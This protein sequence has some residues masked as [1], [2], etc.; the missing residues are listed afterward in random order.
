MKKT[1]AFLFLLG[2][3]A[4][5]PAG[6]SLG[7]PAAVKKR[8]DKLDDK[9]RAH[10]A[11]AAAPDRAPQIASAAADSTTTAAG[12]L[13]R[14]SVAA[15]DPDLD[16]LTYV[17]TSTAGTFGGS[18]ASVYWLAPP[19]AGG[20]A[21]SCAV[22]D[23]KLSVSTSVYVRA[24]PGG[25]IKWKFTAAGALN[26]A[27]VIG[28]D[29]T[30]YIT[31]LSG[32]VYAVGAGGA[33]KWANLG[34][35]L[36]A[37]SM[38]YSP[39]LAP[40]GSVYAVD[41][42]ALAVYAFNPDGT[43]KWSS[44]MTLLSSPPVSLDAPPV[45]G[46]DGK[47]YVY[48]AASLAVWALDPATGVAVS[49][50]TDLSGIL[51]AP[52]AGPNGSIYVAANDGTDDLLYAVPAAGLGAATTTVVNGITMPPAVGA[53]GSVYWTDGSAAYAAKPDGTAKWLTPFSY[54]PDTA[55]IG[56]LLGGDGNIYVVDTLAGLERLD[57]A[58]GSLSRAFTAF[59]T[60]L[61]Q[62][63]AAGPDG[64][65]Y[66]VSGGS[67]A[68]LYSETSGDVLSWGPFTVQAPGLSIVAAPVVT[69]GGAVYAA[70]D[71]GSLYSLYTTS[72]LP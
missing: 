65:V 45:V 24:V 44:D 53:D 50:F 69:A 51:A 36:G 11:A 62:P 12:G 1:L 70:A 10:L 29:G 39:A 20:Y 60:A 32:D 37:M 22:S 14:V 58:T 38:S 66:G 27:P 3:A 25:T 46:P 8:V 56:P 63:A 4:P 42:G 23:G 33:Q 18:G 13:V 71:D 2:L 72:K 43:V 57:P 68:D 67:G 59:P 6:F 64:A 5:A 28:P 17:W 48:D 15:S 54:T 34:V 61:W 9:V 19:A 35:D 40:D 55:D 7:R 52:A 30:A 31:D 16:A 47:V 41:D 49:T 21:L 26:S